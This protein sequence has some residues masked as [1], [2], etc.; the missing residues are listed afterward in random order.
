VLPSCLSPWAPLSIRSG[1]WLI[2]LPLFFLAGVVHADKRL[3][4]SLPAQRPDMSPLYNLARLVA[5]ANIES[6]QTGAYDG[7]TPP[8]RRLI[9]KDIDVPI[10]SNTAAAAAASATPINRGMPRTTKI[11]LAMIPVFVTI[12]GVYVVF[13]FWWR[14]RRTARKEKR[15][16]IS[17]PVPVKDITVY[18]SSIESNKRSSKVYRMAAFAAP[19]HDGRRREARFSGIIAA[20]PEQKPSS[21]ME[22]VRAK[23]TATPRTSLN[24]SEAGL[25]SPT[26]RD[27]PFRLK[28][29]DTLQRMSLGP[30]LARLWPAPLTSARMKPLRTDDKQPAHTIRRDDAV[31]Q[32]GPVRD[33]Q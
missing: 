32:Q 15:L 8:T 2:V 13:L 4:I 24:M 22:D 30:E 31:Y 23:S 11:G 3:P 17:P 16:S 14:K 21:R 20:Q 33:Q 12:V 19:I 28:R 1:I 6:T 25:D 9:Q 29:S 18:P 5:R 27:C 10:P 7:G 26:D